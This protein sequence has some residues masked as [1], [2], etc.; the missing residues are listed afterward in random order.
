MSGLVEF[1]I[2]LLAAAIADSLPP[3]TPD[4]GVE[5]TINLV[6]SGNTMLSENIMCPKLPLRIF[7]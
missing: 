3:I 1:A 6:C 2:V 4:D 7:V 5:N